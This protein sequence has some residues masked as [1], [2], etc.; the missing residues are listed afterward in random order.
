MSKYRAIKTVVGD[1]TFD[2]KAEARR[3][4]ELRLMERAGLIENLQ[5]QIPIVLLPTVKFHDAKRAQPALRY[6]PDFT[7]YEWQAGKKIKVVED[8]KGIQTP[9]FV[10]K[11]HAL[12]AL[13]NIDV[14]VTK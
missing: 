3:Y 2:S 8:V 9:A 7:Y 12:K 14:L 5:R 11:R 4:G 10:I 1:L 6:I 13:F